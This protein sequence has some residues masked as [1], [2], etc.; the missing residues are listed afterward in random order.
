MYDIERKIS[1]NTNVVKSREK[2]EP[3][4][5][6]PPRNF[7]SKGLGKYKYP[8]C[9][10]IPAGKYFSKITDVRFSKTQT[11]KDAVEVF[12]EIK[13][14]KTCYE[15][16]N[17]IIPNDTENKPYYIKQKYIEGTKY[18]DEFTDS[19][20]EALEEYTFKVDKVIGVTEFITLS[21]DKSDI[22][23]FSDRTPLEWDDFIISNQDIQ[24]EE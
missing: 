21:Y 22:G 16:A 13:D 7:K 1:M 19:M 8:N 6:K 5:K 15:I 9:Y 24:D 14:G 4:V 20:A 12:Y 3:I 10:E 2:V 23:G 17:G 18:H 11:G